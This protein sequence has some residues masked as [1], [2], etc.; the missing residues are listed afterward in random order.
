MKHYKNLMSALGDAMPMCLA[1]RL[2]GTEDNYFNAR[3]LFAFALTDDEAD[4]ALKE[5]QF[6]LVSAEGAIGIASGYEYLVKWLFIPL[7]GEVYEQEMLRLK[8]ELERD[9]QPQPAPQPQWTSPPQWT[10]EPQGRPQPQWTAQQEPQA[11]QE[12]Q[13]A[14]QSAPQERPQ[15]QWTSQPE[16]QGRQPQWNAQQEPQGRPQ[17]APRAVPQPQ[18]ADNRQQEWAPQAGQALFCS[19]CGARMNPNAKFCAK[20][21]TPV[22]R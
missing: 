17:P 4:G 14:P 3:D 12:P 7:E 22:S 1:W 18:Q 2:V 10:S 9:A 16:S 20:C 13:W 6:Y 21:G 11:V 5:G 15:P 8:E 19:A